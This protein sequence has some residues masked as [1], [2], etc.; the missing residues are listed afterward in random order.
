MDTREKREDVR[1]WKN[2]NKTVNETN[3]EEERTVLT[4]G[5]KVVR[6]GEFW[7][8]NTDIASLHCR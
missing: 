1:Y 2:I 6:L 7:K 5:V 3:K 8:G 4:T